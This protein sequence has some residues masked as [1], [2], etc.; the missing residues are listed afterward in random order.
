MTAPASGSMPGGP[1]RAGAVVMCS[2]RQSGS[3]SSRDCQGA[4]PSLR[5]ASR[6]APAAVANT[7]GVRAR[8]ARRADQLNMGSLSGS[9]T[10]VL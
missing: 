3:V 9:P 4:R 1:W 5:S 8:K 6:R 2:R 7:R 10:C